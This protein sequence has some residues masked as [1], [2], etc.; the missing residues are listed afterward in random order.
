[1]KLSCPICG[2]K[3]TNNQVC[4]YCNVTD[5]QIL[6]ASNKKV[7]EYKKTGKKDLIYFSNS[8][9]KDVEKWKIILFTVLFGWLGINYFYIN[10]PYRGTFSLVS[11]LGSFLMVIIGVAF[12]LLESTNNLFVV[13]YQILFYMMAINVLL[14]IVDIFSVLMGKLKYP[15]VLPK[16]G[17]EL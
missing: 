11:S 1:M 8:K 4:K 16:Q 15:V 3:L 13:L 5:T 12:N 17:E 2:A 14:W 10:R 9:P 7:K 6:N